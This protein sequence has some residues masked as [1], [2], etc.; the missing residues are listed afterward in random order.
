MRS[1]G[2]EILK[3]AGKKILSGK[4]NLTTISFPIKCMCPKSMLE[5][6]STI[7]GVFIFYLHAA[8]QVS[9]PLERFKLVMAGSIATI[10]PTHQF[11]KPLNPILGET[12]EAVGQDGTKIYLEQIIHRPPV[13][14]FEFEGPDNLWRIT[15]WSSWQAK[16][17]INSGQL[18]VEGSKTCTFHDGQ[19]IKFNNTGD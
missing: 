16:A 10:F 13:T 14:A 17:W 7:A 3:E 5:V 6:Q 9:D 19:T 12:Y 8:A 15:G 11:E 18:I 1:A 4:F 2:K